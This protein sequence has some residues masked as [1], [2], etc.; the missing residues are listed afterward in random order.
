MFRLFK[1]PTVICCLAVILQTG[2][3]NE[4]YKQTKAAWI[5][6]ALN[7]LSSGRYPKV[8]AVAWWHENFDETRL[9]LDSSKESLLA[10]QEGIAPSNF[11]SQ[12]Q[13]ISKKLQLPP[14]G[15]IY[16]A[17][18]PD[19]GGTEDNVTS[20]RI[21]RFEV[22]A[23]KKIVWAYF[24]N[25]WY[26]TIK[27]PLSEVKI[28]HES[29]KLP[30]IRLMPRSDFNE[31]GPDPLYTMQKIIDG[32]FDK[33]LSEWAM[34]A[35]KIGI[36]LLVEFGTEVNGDWFPWNGSYNG[37]GIKDIYGDKNKADGPER[38]RDAYRHIIDLFRSHGVDNIT[39][40]FHVNAS[41][42]PE[43]PWNEIRQYY[44]GDTYIDWIGISV[45]GVQSKGETYYSF[46]EIMD[47]IYPIILK[48]SDKPIAILE[49][50]MTEI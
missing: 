42:Y 30:F 13:I 9:R 18:N 25:N 46:V 24:S 5:T 12:A 37:G 7:S 44:P 19:F 2:Y 29:G 39:W 40:F 8:K 21:K 47:T 38:F 16:H 35:K 1:L 14:L 34:D 32:K 50:G 49:W 41:S 45:Y 48:V 36:P 4:P 22:L 26:D 6:D 3:G 43:E 11:I 10:Y 20:E 28:I 15:A 17:A 27:F 33:A 31:G 23:Q